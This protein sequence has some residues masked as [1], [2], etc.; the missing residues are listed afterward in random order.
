MKVFVIFLTLLKLS[1]QSDIFTG[2]KIKSFLIILFSKM[3]SVKGSVHAC[4]ELGKN[5]QI[6]FLFDL[7]LMI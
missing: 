6:V 4:E 5:Y 3:G 2:F 1:T 7:L